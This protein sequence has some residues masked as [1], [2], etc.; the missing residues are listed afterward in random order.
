VDE[1]D[2]ERL[3]RAARRRLRS[4]TYRQMLRMSAH[5]YLGIPLELSDEDAIEVFYEAWRGSQ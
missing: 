2:K 4:F 3:I 5:Q 1:K